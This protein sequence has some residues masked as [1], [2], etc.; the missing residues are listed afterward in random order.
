MYQEM[1]VEGRAPDI[2]DHV[3]LT[4]DG[5][6][7]V[8]FA[9]TG[10]TKRFQRITLSPIH[11]INAKNFSNSVFVE[12]EGESRFSLVLEANE[13]DY[14]DALKLRRCVV[15][16][17]DTEVSANAALGLLKNALGGSRAAAKADTDVEPAYTPAARSSEV[18]TTILCVS[19]GAALLAMGAGAL[20]TGLALFHKFYV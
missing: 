4:D 17:F 11:R 15:E 16:Q 1:E 20:L 18:G 19:I 12:S 10:I 8:E 6:L 7:V 5:D 2:I 13:Y 3:D 9:K 14:C